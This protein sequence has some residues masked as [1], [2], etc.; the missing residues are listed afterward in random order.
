MWRCVTRAKPKR[1]WHYS[2]SDNPILV[3]RPHVLPVPKGVDI[4]PDQIIP[5]WYLFYHNFSR[6]R[7]RYTTVTHS[8]IID[9]K[10]VDMA[11][12]D[13]MMRKCNNILVAGSRPASCTLY[14]QLSNEC[15]LLLRNWMDL[16][17]WWI[18]R[19]RDMSSRQQIYIRSGF[20]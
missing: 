3:W 11:N 4:T 12:V 10:P 20:S 17:S 13:T 15:M 2:R 14:K 6:E 18:S 7:T 5:F 16:S 8:P 1:C 19:G 9:A